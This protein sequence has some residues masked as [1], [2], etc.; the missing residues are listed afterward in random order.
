MNN[1]RAFLITALA[2]TAIS[3]TG[4]AQTT[5]P[6]GNST[7]AGNGNSG[8][9]AP[10][11][12]QTT[13]QSG[14]TTPPAGQ[15]TSPAGQT[16]SPAGDADAPMNGT[17]STNNMN[18]SPS[19]DS[20]N[21]FVTAQPSDILSYNI[22]GLNITNDADETVGEIKDLIISNNMLAGYIVS[23]GGFL[24]LGE[25]YAIVSPDAVSI[26]YNETDKKWTARMAT[27]KEL[28]KEAPEFRYEGRWQR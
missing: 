8:V 2:A 5:A 3:S 12:E 26:Q 10:S 17:N 24:G 4:F 6:A 25:R 13:P 18:S 11:A 21:G 27:T 23:V 20:N 28:L 15:T 1:L 19:N 22:I 7:D 14:Q 16:T 9:T